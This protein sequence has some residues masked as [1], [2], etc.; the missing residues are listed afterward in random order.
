[1][2][3]NIKIYA[4]DEY[5]RHIFADLGVTVV[6]APNVADVAFTGT[7]IDLPISIADLKSF[8][9]NSSD[10]HDIIKS[11]LGQYVLLPTLQ[12]K[13]IVTLYKNPDISIAELKEILGFLPNVTTH[14]VENAIYQLRKTYGRDVILNTRGKYRIGR[15]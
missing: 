7:D 4:T 15:V 5:W 12:H 9:F 14:T 13:I 11:V 8:I 3:E 10:N 6:D 2:A 1:M